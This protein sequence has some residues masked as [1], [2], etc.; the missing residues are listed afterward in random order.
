[1]D[2]SLI[3]KVIT[4]LAVLVNLLL[5]FLI[6][7]RN[8]RSATGILF[9]LFTISLA[10]ASFANFY[11]LN[12]S[13]DL[14]TLF[15]IRMVMFFAGPMGTFFYLFVVAF[16]NDKMQI[17][18]GW[19]WFVIF[20]SIL[21]PVLALSPLLFSGIAHKNGSIQ[22][23]PGN[24]IVVY[25]LGMVSFLILGMVILSRKFLSGD[26]ALKLRVKYMMIGLALTLG[27]IL[28]F[29]VF[30]VNVFKISNYQFLAGFFTLFYISFTAYAI[31]KHQLFNIKVIA[32][33]T[34]VVALSIAL[35]VE[36]FVSNNITEGALKAIVWVVATY[37]G[38][39]LI[40]SV[41]TEIKQREQLQLLA[42]KLD[43]AN[44][45]LEQLDEAKDNFLSMAAHELNTPIA[46]IEG[47]LS[48]IIEENMGGKIPSKAMVYLKNVFLSSKRLAGL[49]HDLLNVSRI[50][51]NRIHVVYAEAQIEDIIDQSIAEVKIKAD[52]VGH[53]LTFEKPDKPLPKTYMD[54]SRIVEVVINIIGNAIKYTDAP[55]KIDVKCHADDGKI[56]VSIEDNGRGIPKD[57]TDHVFEKFTQVNVLTDQIKGSGLGMFISKN[58]IELHK[59]KLWFE[60]STDEKD[61]GTTFFFSLPILKTK[62]FDP[63]EGEGALLQTKDK[64]GAGAAQPAS[65]TTPDAKEAPKQEKIA[66]VTDGEKKQGQLTPPNLP[67]KSGGTKDATATQN[68]A[69][70]AEIEKLTSNSKESATNSMG[71]KLEA[72]IPT[73]AKK[74]E[75][76]TEDVKNDKESEKLIKQAVEEAEKA[77]TTSLNET[78]SKLKD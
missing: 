36:V 6:W 59:G 19:F 61:H 11:S 54:V 5:G 55:G 15:W 70:I 31:V 64:G 3:E 68:K 53:K 66:D 35:F 50:E 48:M 1:M 39:V 33:E 69:P 77:P 62:P 52:E 67:L 75:S 23:L 30:L 46:A 22:P 21:M 27:S 63:H 58:L 4:G 45:D 65:A 60:S 73:E 76:K 51:S 10:G 71:A 28:F 8:R 29:N 20:L 25:M 41:K 24:G 32:T 74:T 7:S 40:K 16:P 56:V 14:S 2:L 38:F 57:K 12:S 47:Y 78:M 9:F 18:K 17:R 43:K 37:G 44:M 72:E 42:R 49:V 26:G 13:S 34:T